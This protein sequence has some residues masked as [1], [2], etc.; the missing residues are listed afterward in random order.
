M[1]PT[2]GLRLHYSFRATDYRSEQH[3]LHVLRVDQTSQI[4]QTNH[5]AMTFNYWNW[6]FEKN[7]LEPATEG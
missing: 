4:V 6:L 2:P 7:M 5:G 1:P 3:E